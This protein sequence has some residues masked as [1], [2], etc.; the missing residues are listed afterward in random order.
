MRKAW[1]A[2]VGIAMALGVGWGQSPANLLTDGD[3]S[4]GQQGEVGVGSTALPGWTVLAGKVHAGGDHIQFLAPG[5]VLKQSFATVRGQR[6]RLHFQ[7]SGFPRGITTKTMLLSVGDQ[8]RSYRFEIPADHWPV[9][10]SDQT[11]VFKADSTQTD[12]FFT[13]T[14]ADDHGCMLFDVSVIPWTAEAE[15]RAAIDTAYVNLQS[16]VQRRYSA[17]LERLVGAQFTFTRADGS[18]QS[19]SDYLKSL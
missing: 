5:T 11:I 8:T 4:Q 14:V 10:M 3:F 15:R 12:L 18:T 17:Y 1:M 7:L 6:Y 16:A 19:R 2:L 13:G 9:P